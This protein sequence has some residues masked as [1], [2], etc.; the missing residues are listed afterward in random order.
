[1]NDVTWYKTATTQPANGE[2][3]W[4][5]NG[6]GERQARWDGKAREWWRVD[7]THDWRASATC[8]E[9][10][11]EWDGYAPAPEPVAEAAQMGMEV[12]M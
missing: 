6:H 12:G 8:Y 5:R 4:V 7:A 10:W 11:R 9:E 1:M 3:V 2:R